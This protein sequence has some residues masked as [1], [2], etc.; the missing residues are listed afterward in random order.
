MGIR[1][2]NDSGA[3]NGKSLE[4]IKQGLMFAAEMFGYLEKVSQSLVCGLG[5]LER[6]RAS[7]R[8]HRTPIDWQAFIS[9]LE[10]RDL[11]LADLL[12]RA[13]MERFD[14]GRLWIAAADA[15]TQTM[16]K[17]M[18]DRIAS[19]LSDRYGI[20]FAVKIISQ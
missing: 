12:S 11:E 19:V 7:I 20:K 18:K 1:T 6:V 2:N 17:I 9:D 15:Q 13:N 5:E 10:M 4:Q 16:L 3:P 8:Q 14:L